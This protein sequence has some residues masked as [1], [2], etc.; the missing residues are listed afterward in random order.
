MEKQDRVQANTPANIK[1]K[2]E[3]DI[4]HSIRY[5]S[6]NKKE[7]PPRLRE[8][9]AEWDIERTLE[10]NAAVLALAGTLLAA[11]HNRKWLILPAIVTS[12]LTQHATQGW[13]PPLPLLRSLGIRTRQEIDSEKYALKALL[14]EFK[15]THK[16]R[17]VF[18]AATH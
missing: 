5:Y 8:L 17:E 7:I 14:G 18:E 9:D 2:I 3:R 10:L 11:F 6:H 4:L 1:E 13:C 12:F 15:D 16:T